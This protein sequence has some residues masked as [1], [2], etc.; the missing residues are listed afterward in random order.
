[1]VIMQ[2]PCQIELTIDEKGNVE[3]AVDG[4]QGKA[5]LALTAQVESALGIITD[6]KLSPEYTQTN[7]T[8]PIQQQLKKGAT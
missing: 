6:R 5:C 3:I 2:L 7:I 1:M 4:V 8:S